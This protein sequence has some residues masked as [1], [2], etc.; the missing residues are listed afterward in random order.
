[1]QNSTPSPAPPSALQGCLRRYAR[2]VVLQLAI[3]IGVLL[4][5]GSCM[6]A[7]MPLLMLL[8]APSDAAFLLSFIGGLFVTLAVFS[9]GIIVWRVRQDRRMDA[10]FAPLGLQGRMYMISGRRHEGTFEGARVEST[11]YRGPILDL[12]LYAPF[13]AEATF[14]VD[15]AVARA[16]GSAFN[17]EPIV[18][19][20]P[21]LADFLISGPDRTW[22]NGVL[23][24]EAARGEIVT[25]L[26]TPNPPG[27]PLLQFQADRLLLRFAYAD[28]KKVSS[29]QLQQW[30]GA[31]AALARR[32]AELPPPAVAA[33]PQLMDQRIRRGALS[34]PWVIAGIAG[35]IV[36]VLMTCGVGGVILV[37]ALSG[38][39]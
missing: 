23:G 36:A 1:M 5:W 4:I 32:L 7:G 16:A 17:R 39:F 21:A 33:K 26:R 19:N 30:L 6:A 10:A 25:L 27:S 35:G 24:D 37:L 31:M 11:Y 8:Q 22:I 13:G 18:S 15:N 34:S 12:F 14:G 2:G 29:A 20:D 38:G 3:V 9:G 28:I